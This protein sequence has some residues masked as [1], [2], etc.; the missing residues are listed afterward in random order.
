VELFPLNIYFN[1]EF[2]GITMSSELKRKI[3]TFCMIGFAIYTVFN[4]LAMLS[5]PGGTSSDEGKLGYSF[6]DNFFSDLGMINTYAGEP[7]TLSLLL[8]ASALV[9]IG[10]VLI[11]LFLV[12]LSYF[13]NSTAERNSSKIGTLAGILSGIACIGM[14]LTP[15][16]RFLDL[17]M[18]FAFGFS[19]SFIVAAFFYMLAI[20]KNYMYP[21]MYAAVF[22]IY[23]LILAVF[24]GLMLW[25]PDIETHEGIRILATGQKICI[26]SGMICLFI[27]VVGAYSYN[28][29]YEVLQVA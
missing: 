13:R 21:N 3:L 1:G 10:V 29:K 17:H 25:G 26:Y 9:L 8:F 18:V 4:I 6:F 19:F 28:Q 11:L 12:L 5:Y 14:A 23:I 16:D 20:M 15:W 7:N 27:Q 22:G 24:I 2:K